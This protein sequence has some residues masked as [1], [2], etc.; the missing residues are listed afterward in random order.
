MRQKSHADL[1]KTEVVIGVAEGERASVEKALTK[2]TTSNEEAVAKA[3]AT[4]AKALSIENVA[5]TNAE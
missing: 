5:W 1:K 2:A 4:K 3:N